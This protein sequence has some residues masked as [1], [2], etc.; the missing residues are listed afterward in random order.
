MDNAT[1]RAKLREYITKDVLRDASYPLK[2][3]EKL[4]STSLVDSFSLMDLA[5][6]VENNLGVRLEDTELNSDN[7]DTLAELAS[8]IEQRQ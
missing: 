6:W 7:F 5:L 1:L 4:I 2:D 8:Y 3:D